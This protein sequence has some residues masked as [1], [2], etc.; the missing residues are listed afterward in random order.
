MWEMK[1][2]SLVRAQEESCST[3]MKQLPQ[4]KRNGAYPDVAD[5]R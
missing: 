4:K 3:K 1:N 5:L 2:W